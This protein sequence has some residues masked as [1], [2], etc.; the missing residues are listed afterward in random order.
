VGAPAPIR[1]CRAP[2]GRVTAR[3]M[4]NSMDH[5][6]SHEGDRERDDRKETVDPNAHPTP[7]NPETDVESVR[8]GKEQ[9]G[10]IVSW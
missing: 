3:H 5:P 7:S 9:M 1:V 2:E 8:K 10:R 6:Q 4:S